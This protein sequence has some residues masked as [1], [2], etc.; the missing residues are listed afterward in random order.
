MPLVAGDDL[1]TG[2]LIGHHAGVIVLGIE[3]LREGR[4]PHEVNE[5]HRQ[6]PTLDGTDAAHGIVLKL[7]DCTEESPAMADRRNPHLLQVFGGQLAEDV[8][9]DVVAAESLFVLLQSEAPQP[10]RDVHSISPFDRAYSLS[11]AQYV[12]I[13]GD[14]GC[15]QQSWQR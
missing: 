12:S 1:L 2:R 14:A 10:G 9:A 11:V 5:H 15:I 3:L 6:L 4:G 8:R 7:G 13:I